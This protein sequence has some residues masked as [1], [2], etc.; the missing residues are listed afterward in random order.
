MNKK[1]RRGKARCI[2]WQ[3][4]WGQGARKIPKT[5]RRISSKDERR[6][7]KKEINSAADQ[8]RLNFL[9][10]ADPVDL[11]NLCIFF[12]GGDGSDFIR[13][14]NVDLKGKKIEMISLVYS[15]ASSDDF[16]PAPGQ[17]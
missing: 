9:P 7:S 2:K 12:E 6:E 4:A 1:R 5:L 3:R 10:D 14:K 16:L 13:F 17:A 11:P 15:D 8:T